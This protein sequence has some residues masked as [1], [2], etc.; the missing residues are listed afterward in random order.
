MSEQA[1]YT[2]PLPA[3]DPTGRDK[4]LPPSGEVSANHGQ[5]EL[6]QLPRDPRKSISYED[7]NDRPYPSNQAT[8][9]KPT[10]H[11]SVEER[12][13]TPS[14][15]SISAVSDSSSQMETGIQPSPS[16]STIPSSSTP[17]TNII[18]RQHNDGASPNKGIAESLDSL[19]KLRQFKAEVE[20]TRQNT[21]LNKSTVL[22]GE[23]NPS[24]LAKMAESFI[25]QQQLKSGDA[26]SAPDMTGQNV[27]TSA[28]EDKEKELKEKLLS[29]SQ[30]RSM[31]IS[32]N[33][34]KRERGR[35]DSPY[36]ERAL[37]SGQQENK[38]MRNDVSLPPHAPW[39]ERARGGEYDYAPAPVKRDQNYENDRFRPPHADDPRFTR[40]EQFTPTSERG[41]AALRYQRD[42]SGSG[43]GSGADRRYSAGNGG[44]SRTP[45]SVRNGRDV[46]SYANERGR[47]EYRIEGQRL[48]DRISGPGPATVPKYRPRSPS[49]P[50]RV[51]PRTYTNARPPSPPRP[52]RESRERDYPRPPSPPRHYPDPRTPVNASFGRR[53]D[54]PDPYDTYANARG[55][56]TGPKGIAPDPYA[57]APSP[58]YG[59]PP[60][61]PSR[62]Y[63]REQRYGYNQRAREA[64]YSRGNPPPPPP[65]YRDQGR[66]DRPP[67]LPPAGN[68]LMHGAGVD[69]TNV[70][71]TLEALKAQISKLEKLVPTANTSAPPPPHQGY[72]TYADYTSSYERDRLREPHPREREYA[73]DSRPPPPPPPGNAYPPSMGGR[74]RPRPPSPPPPPPQH[75]GGVYEHEYDLGHGHG[76]GRGYD[77]EHGHEFDYDDRGH[78]GGRGGHGRGRGGRGRG[79]RGQRGRGGRGGR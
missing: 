6:P 56:P 55:P 75:R 79:G 34:N 21:N 13:P 29:K 3:G 15:T 20:A 50:S 51:P 25:M 31:N 9:P 46:G 23:M 41:N 22:A 18:Q 17:S 62:E 38:R 67:P 27:S 14:L 58:G 68:P 64:S 10:P 37:T 33:A 53:T 69:T 36:N 42:V 32:D 66:Y 60:P 73:Y 63:G 72:D 71:E 48:A 24:Q 49:P 74:D 45:P 39:D 54:H 78:P 52:P 35:T 40:R 57:R 8:A 12:F 1:L 4:A 2:P 5:V 28:A 19:A 11:T 70:V 77:Y 59:R 44:R 47:E 65:E 16:L 76:H 26:S 43:S 30:S 7:L 61:P